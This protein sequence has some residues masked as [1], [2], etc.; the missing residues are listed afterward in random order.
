MKDLKYPFDSK[1]TTPK[2]SKV[3]HVIVLWSILKWQIAKLC[4][5]D[6]PEN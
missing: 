4:H 1:N 3:D 2:P 6:G 5:P